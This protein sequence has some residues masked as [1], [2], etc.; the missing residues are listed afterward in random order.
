VSTYDLVLVFGPF[1]FFGFVAMACF[2]V[3][4]ER[5]GRVEF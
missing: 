3:A 5:Y 1:F 4:D 2:L